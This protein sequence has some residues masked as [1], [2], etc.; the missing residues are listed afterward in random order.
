MIR[1]LELLSTTALG[2][3]PRQ[4]Y[5][6]VRH[7]PAA[8]FE[9]VVA[10]P[11]DGAFFERFHELG[12]AVTAIGANRLGPRPLVATVRLVRGSGI[13]LIHTHGKGAGLYGRLAARGTGV[14]AIHTFH[15]IHF[16]SYPRGVQKAYLEL[17][18]RL[19]R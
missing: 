5:D 18:R 3:G 9:V 14:P 1:V 10:G 11:R 8:E 2:G 19:A 13:R 17:E 6:L 16:E 7:L 4:V 12:L 15:G